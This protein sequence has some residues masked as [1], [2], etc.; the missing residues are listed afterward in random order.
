MK[1]TEKLLIDITYNLLY[2]KGYCA[3]S[4]MDILQE[5]KITKG[6]MYYHFANKNDLVLA[7]MKYYLD[8][9][10]QT[11]WV[12]PFKESEYPLDAVVNQIN[13]Y[14]AVF[15]D[16]NSPIDIKHG[17]PL[18]NFTLDMSDKD[19]SFFEYLQGVYSKW[20]ES[21]SNALQRAKELNQTRIDFNPDNE[22]LFIISS[23]EGSIGVA[24]AHNN[25]EILR[26]S[27]AVLTK[28]IQNL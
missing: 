12:D 5:A 8:Y 15:E 4:L 22:A 6:A 3:T 19:E 27:F 10:L 1:K 16:M 23:I 13:A 7:S 25:L 11:H 18:M 14:L 9:I 26:T 21:I 20:Q 28:H 17:C 2:R 24:K